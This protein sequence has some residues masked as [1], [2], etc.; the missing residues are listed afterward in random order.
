M[1]KTKIAVGIL[2]THVALGSVPALN[3]QVLDNPVDIPVTVHAKF[4][5]STTET[6][7]LTWYGETTSSSDDTTWSKQGSGWTYTDAQQ[8]DLRPGKTYDLRLSGNGN[9]RAPTLELAGPPG[10]DFFISDISGSDLIS[11]TK[12]SGTT[13]GTPDDY[14]IMVRPS[15][16][17]GS[18]IPFGESTSWATDKLI[19]RSGLGQLKNGSSAGAISIGAEAFGSIAYQP[20]DLYYSAPSSE[21]SVIYSSGVLRQVNAPQGLADIVTVN[22]TTYEIRYYS[23]KDVGPLSGGVYTLVGSPS[24]VATY[25]IYQAATNNIEIKKT[26]G[27]DY[28][29][30]RLNWVYALDS[31]EMHD[32]TKN[33]SPYDNSMRKAI[34]TNTTAGSTKTTVVSEYGWEVGTDGSYT[35][36]DYDPQQ[37][38]PPSSTYESTPSRRTRKTYTSYAWGRE[39]TKLEEGWDG[40]SSA[41]RTTDYEYYTNVTDGLGHYRQLKKVTYPDGGYKRYVY[42]DA[43]EKIGLVKEVYAPFE[44]SNEG[45][46]TVYAYGTDASGERM[47]PTSIITSVKDGGGTYQKVGERSIAYNTT[48]LTIN[49]E[50][51]RKETITDSASSGETE[52]TVRQIYQE[53]AS[54][55]YLRGQ[56]YSIKNPDGTQ[57][58][59]AYYTTSIYEYYDGAYV[60]RT[61]YVKDAVLGNSSAPSGETSSSLSSLNGDTIES[62]YVIEKKSTL[63]EA[64]YDVAGLQTSSQLRLNTTGTSFELAAADSIGYDDAGR[65]TLVRKLTYAN[66]S[67][68]ATNTQYEATYVSGQ[69]YTQKDEVGNLKTF[70]YDRQGRVEEIFIDGF[71]ADTGAGTPEVYDVWESVRF[72]GANQRIRSERSD[73]NASEAVVSTWAYD[74]AGR[75]TSKTLD[76]CRTVTVQYPAVDQVKTINPDGGYRLEEYYRDGTLKSVTGDAQPPRYVSSRVANNRI[77]TWSALES[78]SAGTYKD[79]W[80]IECR[81]W[82]GR[83]VEVEEPTWNASN[84]HPMRRTYVEYEDGQ[85][86]RTYRKHEVWEEENEEYALSSS[87]Y[88]TVFEHD[89]LGRLKRTALDTN[90][91]QVVDLSVDRQIAETRV[92]F[93]ED[94]SGYWWQS[95]RKYAYPNPSPNADTAEAVSEER[96]RLAPDSNSLGKRISIDL[97][98]EEDTGSNGRPKATRTL[99]VDRTKALVTETTSFDPYPTGD[100]VRLFKAGLLVKDTDPAG[101]KVEIEYDNLRR[102][103]STTERGAVKTLLTYENGSMDRVKYVAR[104]YGPGTVT[105]QENVYGSTTGRLDRHI[106]RNLVYGTQRWENTY[107]TYNKQGQVDYQYGDGAFPVD[108]VYNS[109]GQLT[110]IHQYRNTSGTNKTTVKML[111]DDESGLLEEKRHYSTTSAYKATKYEYNDLDKVSKRIWA[112]ASGTLK[113]TYL[114]DSNER[115]LW[116]EDYSD[117]TPDVTYTYDRMGRVETVNDAAGTRKF[118]RD[119]TY[120]NLLTLEEDLDTS[121]SGKYGSLTVRY[122]TEDGSGSTV[123]GRAKGVELGTGTGGSFSAYQRQHYGYETTGGRIA[124]VLTWTSLYNWSRQYNFTYHTNS[125]LMK[126]TSY[127]LYYKRSTEYETWRSNRTR[128]KTEGGNGSTLTVKS[129]FTVPVFTWQD[130]IETWRL[131]GTTATDELTDHYGWPTT[132]DVK[133]KYDLQGQVIERDYLFFTGVENTYSWDSAGNQ[134]NFNGSTYTVNGLNQIEPTGGS[135]TDFDY[136]DDGNLIGDLDWTYTYDA[137]NRLTQLVSKTGNPVHPKRLELE[138]DYLHR[139]IEKRVYNATSGGSAVWQNRFVY[140]GYNVIAEVDTSQNVERSFHWGL[141]RASSLTAT[142]GLEGLLLITRWDGPYAYWPVYDLH[143]NVVG[144]TNRSQA[145]EAAY[146]YDSFGAATKVGTLAYNSDNPFRFATKYTDDESGLV[147]FGHRYYNPK[148]GRFI[149]RDPIEE[150]GGFNLYRYTN[151]DAINRWDYLGMAGWTKD[152]DGEEIYEMDPFVVGGNDGPYDG[153]GS[154][155]VYNLA[156][157]NLSS[158]IDLGSAM[159][160]SQFNVPGAAAA[161]QTQ[162]GEEEEKK[163]GCAQLRKDYPIAFQRPGTAFPNGTGLKDA[164]IA[165]TIQSAAPTRNTDIEHAVAVLGYPNGSLSLS[166]VVEGVLKGAEFRFNFALDPVGHQ[167]IRGVGHSHDISY[168]SWEMV[169]RNRSLEQYSAG[170]EQFSVEDGRTTEALSDLYRATVPIGMHTPSNQLRVLT[171]DSV[172]LGNMNGSKLGNIPAKDVDG[173]IDCLGGATGK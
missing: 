18:M 108:Y 101:T 92:D 88:P 14:K 75:L 150:M 127:G 43:F 122:P 135:S 51:V 134:T 143:S 116:K 69:L 66:G 5:S 82:L 109:Y 118:L 146:Q 71:A 49:G 147:Y 13:L 72:D 32:W 53:D 105:V 7:T 173:I 39:L 170:V 107:Y 79:G 99:A 85:Q 34:T 110:E 151:N 138:Y 9:V 73:S 171:P 137:E 4:Y 48:P 26:V 156:Y 113:T 80:R 36:S 27:S 41:L 130:Q 119:S 78:F 126:D 16:H 123:K 167:E 57:V 45:K 35:D 15:G 93:Y 40:S 47:L 125:N 154:I 70:V 59:F 12:V 63:T 100:R 98:G 121:G 67:L 133:Q 90:N 111:Y 62:T 164:L 21:V 163:V 162:K 158:A 148:T 97:L 20:S 106:R 19:W 52:V 129:D 159:E 131:T 141:D 77:E 8:I 68:Q 161:G 136:D 169:Y 31:W 81:D 140:D 160:G 25:R 54:D 112:R 56:P 153:S 2:L 38:P 89:G 155:P 104:D 145:F 84:G 33:M 58:A 157:S 11:R 128:H 44:D 124:H 37:S 76:C 83:T 166:T 17:A 28:W 86:K 172:I 87:G 142:G 24:P 132:A 61:Y 115:R 149:N 144:L 152:S 22:S 120:G 65:V 102:K 30:T 74:V 96:V 55:A 168:S 60:W 10:Y 1:T 91:N 6:M 94:S 95:T 50:P 46:K 23:W 42:E 117:S 3:A 64:W 29:I 114:Y 103:Y 165:A 139:R